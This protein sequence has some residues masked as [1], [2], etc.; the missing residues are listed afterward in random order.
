MGHRIPADPMRVNTN[1]D[2]EV[3]HWCAE[4]D[5]SSDELREAVS[6][7]GVEVENVRLHLSQRGH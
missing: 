7:V 6:A 3:E 2:A 4:F 5:C 1:D